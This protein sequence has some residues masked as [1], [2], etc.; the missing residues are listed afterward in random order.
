MFPA[1]AHLLLA[2]LEIIKDGG[3]IVKPGINRDCLDC[4]AHRVQEPLVG[5][6]VINGCEVRVLPVVVSG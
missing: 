2:C 4:H 6:A 3:I 5:A 1:T